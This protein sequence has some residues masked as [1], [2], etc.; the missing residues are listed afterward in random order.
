MAMLSMP[1]V[2]SLRAQIT[3]VVLLSTITFA[4]GFIS[5]FQAGQKEGSSECSYMS[6]AEKLENAE[7]GSQVTLEDVT[8]SDSDLEITE[9]HASLPVR[10]C[11]AGLGGR[12]ARPKFYQRGS[13]R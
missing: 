8:S 7:I 10:E 12:T 6:P 2:I 9:T 13:P 11:S 4:Y 3:M 1:N 5:A